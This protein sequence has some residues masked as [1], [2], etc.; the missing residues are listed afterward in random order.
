M[1]VAQNIA[2]KGLCHG[3]RAI[4]RIGN[5]KKQV[6]LATNIYEKHVETKKNVV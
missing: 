6:G 5:H 1:D 2:Q 3:E 4:W